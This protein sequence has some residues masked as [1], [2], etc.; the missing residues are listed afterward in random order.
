MEVTFITTLEDQ[1]EI[2]VLN[3][4]IRSNHIDT[5]LNAQKMLNEYSYFYVLVYEEKEL[6]G[7]IYD[8]VRLVSERKAILTSNKDESDYMVKKYEIDNRMKPRIKMTKV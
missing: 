4:A 7:S 2:D 3:D 6:I 8:I 1:K 5:V